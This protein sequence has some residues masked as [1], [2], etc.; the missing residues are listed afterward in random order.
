MEEDTNTAVS[1]LHQW[2]AQGSKQSRRLWIRNVKNKEENKIIVALKEESAEFEL[3]KIVFYLPL[4]E[5]TV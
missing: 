1:S 3:S 4:L 2:K 5:E